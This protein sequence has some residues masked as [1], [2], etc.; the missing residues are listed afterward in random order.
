MGEMHLRTPSPTQTCTQ[1]HMH[2]HAHTNLPSLLHV[3]ERDRV[4]GRM[5]RITWQHACLPYTRTHRHIITHTYT[6]RPPMVAPCMCEE[7]TTRVESGGGWGMCL[8]AYQYP[9]NT[10]TNTPSYTYITHTHTYNHLPLAA[11][12]PPATF[13]QSP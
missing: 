3:C 1:H 7:A 8:I 11:A 4:E 13:L 5:S 2:R 12:P 10:H 9:P 6:Y